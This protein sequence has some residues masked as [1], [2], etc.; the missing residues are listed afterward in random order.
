MLLA[1]C[2]KFLDINKSPNDP[3]AATPQLVLPSGIASSAYVI[4]GWYQLLGGMWAQHWAQSTG[5]GQW[6][7]WED[8]A[9]RGDHYDVYQYGML[10][11]GVLN[12]MEYIRKE[13]M[14]TKDWTYYLIATCIQSYTFQVL[15]DL[16]DKIPFTEALKGTDNLTPK[17]DDGQLVYD[18]LIARLDFAVNKDFTIKSATS[19]LATSSQVGNEDLIFQ[20]DI[21]SWV[22]FANMLK[23]KL[24][25][26][27]VYVRPNIA[28]AGIAE[29]FSA[30]N[31][32]M[33]D[34]AMT[35]FSNEQDKR[36]PIYETGVDR[37]AGNIAASATLLEYLKSSADPRLNRI[38]SPAVANGLMVGIQNGH[39]KSDAA[40]FPNI[41]YLSTPNLGPVDPVYFFSRA[42]CF[43]MLAEAN[44]R[45][46]STSDA[47][48]FY[49]L[50]I[51]SSM[52]KLG[53]TVDTALYSPGGPYEYPATGF[54]DQLRAIIV[55]KWIAAANSQSLEAFF[56][57]NRTGY[58]DFLVISPTNVT[59]GKFPKRLIF[60]ESETKSNPNTPAIVPIY[61]K[62]WWDTKVK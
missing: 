9:L 14:R 52:E 50:G 8:Y 15:A 38:F 11:S 19:P 10:Y 51:Q 58:P 21:D 12:D 45:Y 22:Q 30:N 46:G 62:V 33:R 35:T 20:G 27:Q 40:I 24:F 48:A 6:T 2:D 32:L 39:Y 42:E 23:L 17:W 49:I 37:L 54:E 53:V 7:D 28:Q 26:R 56:D 41:Q 55:Q 29:L 44:L 3:S 5:S 34:A 4:G 59:G 13:T 43:F 47:E 61:T 16:Y 57:Q 31:F 25:L 60:P 36:N 18:S 1:G